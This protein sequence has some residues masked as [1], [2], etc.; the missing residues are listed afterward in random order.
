MMFSVTYRRQLDYNSTGNDWCQQQ[1]SFFDK[2]FSIEKVNSIQEWNLILPNLI[3]VDMEF[4]LSEI[5][6]IL[7]LQI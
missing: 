1:I 5:S 2:F 7:F 4:N 3:H 6:G